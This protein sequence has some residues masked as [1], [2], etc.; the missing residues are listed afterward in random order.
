MASSRKF[1]SP[2]GALFAA[3][4]VVCAVLPILSPWLPL[5]IAGG[6]AAFILIALAG[7]F[8]RISMTKARAQDTVAR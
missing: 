8:I 1:Q 7:A 4:A 3:G 5:R 2:L 6:A